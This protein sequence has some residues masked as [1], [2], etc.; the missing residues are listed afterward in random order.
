ML[1]IH[2]PGSGFVA[3][4][5]ARDHRYRCI[6]DG[7]DEF[8][9]E[10]LPV[11]TEEDIVAWIKARYKILGELWCFNREDTCPSHNVIYESRISPLWFAAGTWNPPHVTK[12]YLVEVEG[13]EKMFV[14]QPNPD[15]FLEWSVKG[16]LGWNGQR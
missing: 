6:V 12:R 5:L 13:M 14:L 9:G 8:R 2:D 1:T 16:A 3:S 15:G 10:R 4:L 7:R 11:G